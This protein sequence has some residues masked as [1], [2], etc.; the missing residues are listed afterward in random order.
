MQ[1]I[2]FARFY[3]IGSS[4][5]EPVREW[6]LGLLPEERRKI[7]R[8]IRLVELGW[9]IGMPTCGPLGDG[10]FEVR[11]NLD[12]RSARILFC[13]A[14]SE[15][16]LLHG[17]MKTTQKTPPRELQLARRRKNELLGG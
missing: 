3:R 2:L 5:P 12:T 8:A 11:V 4:G 7:G 6:L 15:M 16:W 1:K 10:I 9:P 13:I 14:A 17:F